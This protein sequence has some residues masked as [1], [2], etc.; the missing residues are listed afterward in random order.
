[1]VGPSTWHVIDLASGSV[2]SAASF[3]GYDGERWSW[4][5]LDPAARTAYRL[6]PTPNVDPI[7]T[8]GLSLLAIDVATGVTRATL[9][10]PELRISRLQVHHGNR[11]R[12]EVE[13]GPAV[14]VTPDGATLALAH[15]DGLGVTL[16][17]AATLAV[18]RRMVQ[19]RDAAGPDCEPGGRIEHSCWDWPPARIAVFGPDSS[20]LYLAGFGPSPDSNDPIASVDYGLKVLDLDAG[21]MRRDPL[22]LAVTE[23]APA[24]GGTSIYVAGLRPERWGSPLLGEKAALRR[25]DPLTLATTAERS[26]IVLDEVRVLLPWPS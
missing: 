9:D 24:P 8:G 16:L 13:L 2:R 6:V 23:F 20:R 25:L 14:A 19:R 26:D 18:R 22:A 5:V 1:V 15:P 4:P 7:A 3:A 12:Q 11:L 10:L 21:T 17:D